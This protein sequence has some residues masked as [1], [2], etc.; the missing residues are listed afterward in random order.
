MPLVL[1]LLALALVTALLGAVWLEVRR[2]H[3][4]VWLG[5]WLRQ[6]RPAVAAD[7]GPVHVMFCFV[8][9]FEPKWGR[10][11]RPVE[12]ERVRTWCERYR[13]L[14]SRHVDAD[15]VHPQHSFFYP[16]EEY[17]KEHLDAL[18]TLCSQGFGEIEVHLHH[19]HDTADGLREKINRFGRILHERHGALVP[20]PKHPER[21][22]FGFIHGNWALDNSR[23]DGRWCGVNNE[24][25]VLAELGCYADFTMPSAPS[26]TQTPKINSIYYATDDPQRPR[27][28]D[29]GVDVEAG[30][31]ASGDLMLIQ[32]PL[33]LNWRDRKW[34][35]M[36]RT[37]NA[38]VRASS[39]PSPQRTDLWVQQHIHVRGRPEWLFIKVHTHGAQE[40]D[41]DSLL[42]APAQ[43]MYADLGQRYNDGQRHV[44]HY[45]SA[46]EMYNIVKAAEAGEKGNPHQYRDYFLPPPKSS[47]AGGQA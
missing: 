44:L 38:D 20:D 18:A 21:L 34:G 45:V 40:R 46:R 33:A 17:E 29:T 9:H 41:M 6:R 25:Q 12:D 10:P 42:G 43:A 22:A 15:G 7:A 26:D 23:H 4:D 47:R 39:P 3:I 30:R 5:A 13:Q 37:E 36:P 8:D 24:I 16:E 2:K 1:V 14:A 32:G 28:H 35:L 11:Q 31:P 27:S 19:D